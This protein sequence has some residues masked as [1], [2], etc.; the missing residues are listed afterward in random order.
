M[1]IS[2]G[3]TEDLE[4]GYEI[5]SY[6]PHQGMRGGQFDVGRWMIAG[7]FLNDLSKP[8]SKRLLKVSTRQRKPTI[9]WPKHA[10]RQTGPNG[11]G[12]L[13]S[14]VEQ[15]SVLR[16][17]DGIKYAII[18]FGLPDGKTS[19]PQSDHRQDQYQNDRNRN[20]RFPFNND[21]YPFNNRHIA[22]TNAQTFARPLAQRVHLIADSLVIN[23]N[24]CAA[25][26]S[27][28]V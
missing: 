26:L 25:K 2:F 12:L 13:F 5:S 17:R 21:R 27:T 20:D 6:T 19:N 18:E 8:I 16:I 24:L 3:E 23:L 7:Q 1:T 28:P 11:P 10:L 14:S 4:G 22:I 9:G 15:V